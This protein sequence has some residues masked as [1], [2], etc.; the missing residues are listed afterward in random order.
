M[1]IQSIQTNSSKK[2]TS[3]YPAYD[4]SEHNLAECWYVFEELKPEGM[5]LY[6]HRIK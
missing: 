2:K 3:K 6:G 1:K 5:K 4:M